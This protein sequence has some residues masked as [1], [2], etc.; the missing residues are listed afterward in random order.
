MYIENLCNDNWCDSLS[1]QV[2]LVYLGNVY[3]TMH[4]IVH[5]LTLALS[6]RLLHI[7]LLISYN[8]FYYLKYIY[9]PKIYSN[10]VYFYIIIHFFLT[11]VSF[12]YFF[13]FTVLWNP[14]RTMLCRTK[15]VYCKKRKRKYG[16][17]K[18]CW[19]W[20]KHRCNN[21]NHD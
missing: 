3:I 14:R 10:I 19:L 9:L 5:L 4:E 21:S 7:S 1:R 18:N 20:C 17:C 8:T 2:I 16:I 11:W 15:I 13:I 12:K 6:V